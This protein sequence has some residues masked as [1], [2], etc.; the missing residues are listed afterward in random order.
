MWWCV[1]TSGTLWA[2][3][4]TPDP[5]APL[6]IAMKSRREDL[7]LTVVDAAELA[8]LSRSSW[9]ELESGRRKTTFGDTLERID[10]ALQWE[11]GTLRKVVRAS[12]ER[13][14]NEIIVRASNRQRTADMKPPSSY[15][16]GGFTR[17]HLAQVTQ[18][19]PEEDLAPL[20]T[21]ALELLAE[22]LKP[23]QR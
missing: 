1:G 8:G 12:N 21:L 7:G 3:T 2:M 22:R 20:I 13:I 15:L 11:R 14:R 9:H 10:D 19:L 17:A 6:A 16:G 23:K 5:E 18:L 4:A